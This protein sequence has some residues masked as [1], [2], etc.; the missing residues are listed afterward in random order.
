MNRAVV[1][2]A[3]IFESSLPHMMLI[4]SED[5]GRRFLW[6]INTRQQNIRAQKTVNIHVLSKELQISH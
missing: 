3:L 1:Y 6:K 2:P 5:E 4:Y